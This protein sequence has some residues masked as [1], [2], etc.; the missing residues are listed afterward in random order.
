[1]KKP[2]IPTHTRWTGEPAFAP[3]GPKLEPGQ[4]YPVDAVPGLTWDA[5]AAAFNHPLFVLA[6]APA[7]KENSDAQ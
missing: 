2:S 6:S 3:G 1:M 4:V 5:D 7:V